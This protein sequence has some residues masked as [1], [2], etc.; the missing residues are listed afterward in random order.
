M[1]APLLTSLDAGVLMLTLNR[2]DKRN[3]LNAE[4]IDALH[5]SLERADLNA[6]VR[7]IVVR[8]GG[9]DFCAGADLDELLASVERSE[10]E[11]EASALRLG[12]LFERLRALPKPVIAMVHGRALAGGAGL[13]TACDLIVAAA[14]AQVG[15]PEIQR[16][17]APAMVMALLRRIVGEKVALDLVLTGRVLQAEEAERA[18]LISRVVP[19]GELERATLGLAAELARTSGTALALTKRLFY[20]LEGESL[21]DGVARGARVNALARTT[22]DFRNA[23]ARFLKK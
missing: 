22:P 18:G 15:Y 4:L 3:A 8:G 17:F 12:T 2:P 10:A 5:E 16:G 11:N 1:K 13:A 21:A 20:E 14:D 23:I 9:K 6:D 19:P 7:V